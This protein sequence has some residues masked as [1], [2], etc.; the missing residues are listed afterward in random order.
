MTLEDPDEWNTSSDFRT[1]F[2]AAFFSQ[3]SALVKGCQKLVEGR[4]KQPLPPHGNKIGRYTSHH[5]P[6]LAN[7]HRH[8]CEGIVRFSLTDVER[9]SPGG[10]RTRL[11]SKIGHFQTGIAHPTPYLI[12]PGTDLEHPT[13]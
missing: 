13:N 2:L 1:S 4:Q 8:I 12:C 10:I 11:M 5:I 3:G 6:Y 7:A 9:R